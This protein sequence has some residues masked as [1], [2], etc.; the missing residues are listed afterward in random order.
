MKDNNCVEQF[1][2]GGYTCIIAAYMAHYN[3]Y[4]VLT[5][6]SKYYG[7]DYND[8]P[9]ECHGGLTYSNYDQDK[10][11]EI[12]FDCAHFDDL[13]EPSGL[14]ENEKQSYEAVNRVSPTAT[15]K[16]AKFVE[17]ELKNIVRQL[18]ELDT[19]QQ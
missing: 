10:N 11:W 14:P 19:V 6:E 1:E 12:G 16:N 13:Y 3:G 8:I 7:V 15:F 17:G 18:N 2:F 5:K 4:V 9:I